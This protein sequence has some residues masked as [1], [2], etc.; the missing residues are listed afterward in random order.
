MVQPAFSHNDQW[1]CSRYLTK[2]QQKDCQESDHTKRTYAGYIYI[3]VYVSK[4]QYDTI[5]CYKRPE[6]TM[7]C[8]HISTH[9]ITYTY[10]FQHAT[11]QKEK[12]DINDVRNHGILVVRKMVC[13]YIYIFTLHYDTM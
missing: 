2:A 6:A 4:I 8:M 1:P 3:Y 9:I 13:I 5:G 11:K 10:M 12:P 7:V